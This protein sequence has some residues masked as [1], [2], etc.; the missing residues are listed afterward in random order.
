MSAII[1]IE[2]IPKEIRTLVEVGLTNAIKRG[3]LGQA[4]IDSI[5]IENSLSGGKTG[6]A[7]F[8]ARYGVINSDEKK[9]ATALEQT[10][11][12]TSSTFIRVLKIAPKDICEAENEGYIK[13]RETLLDIFSQVEYYP[14]D[15]FEDNGKQYGICTS[16]VGASLQCGSSIFPDLVLGITTDFVS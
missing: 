1:H 15:E 3:H 12:S 6:A 16:P 5:Q 10:E 14:G 13:T 2:K 11:S 8:V 9:N 7:V 4:K